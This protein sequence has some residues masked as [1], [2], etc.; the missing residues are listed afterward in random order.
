MA[1]VLTAIRDRDFKPVASLAIR[2]LPGQMAQILN[3]ARFGETGETYA[4]DVERRHDLGDPIFGGGGAARTDPGRSQRARAGVPRGLETRGHPAVA[5]GASTGER[6]SLPLTLAA[7]RG[8]QRVTGGVE[9]W[10]ATSTTSASPDG[11]RLVLVPD[12]GI[13][14]ITEIDKKEAM[15]RSPSSRRASG[16]GP[17][18]SCW[19]PWPSRSRLARSRPREAGAQGEAARPVHARGEDRRGRHGRGLPGAPRDAAPAHGDQAAPR[20][21]RATTPSVA[22]FEREVQLTSQLTHPNTIA[23]Y[24]YGRTPD[25][26]FYYAMEYLDGIDPRRPGRATTGRSREARVVHILR[27]ICGVAGRG[28]RARARASRHQAGEHHALPSAAALLRRRQGARLRPRQ[29]R[30]SAVEPERHG[31]TAW[32]SARRTTWRPRR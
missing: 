26:I 20:E 1:F 5:P 16:P 15:D 32:W 13:G 19:E 8:H 9:P 6:R 4:V 22:R 7:C 29:G 30:W 10:R 11:R 14:L 27:Q 31:H 25:G 18:C 21:R 2:V 3:L 17:A 28:A 12:L 24:D 23:I